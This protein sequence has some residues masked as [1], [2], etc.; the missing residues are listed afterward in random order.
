MHVHKP[1]TDLKFNVAQLLREEV[2]SRRSYQFSENELRLDATFSLKQLSGT[3]KFTRSA[4]GVLA[5]AS[6]HG[7][8]EMECTRCLTG[9]SQPVDVSFTDEFHSRIEV[10]TGA[11]LPKPEEE[12]PFFIDELH[13]IDLGEALREYGLIAL[14]MQPLC[15]PACRGLCP[16]CGV[17]RNVE[18]CAC[19]DDT[20]DERFA[21]LRSLLD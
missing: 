17:D 15:T 5:E 3:V 12:D 14:P 6:A 21:A 8:A 9:T 20:G 11:P 16:T 18:Q 10:N 7:I 1:N 4:S 13:M 19:V 2:G